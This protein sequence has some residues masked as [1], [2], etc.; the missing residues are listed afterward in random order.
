[1]AQQLSEEQIAARKAKFAAKKARRQQAAKAPGA[2]QAAG[3]V[4]DETEDSREE[5]KTSG[6]T[7]S[8]SEEAQGKAA[9]RPE[10]KKRKSGASVEGEAAQK[11]GRGDRPAKKDKK[12]KK[13]KKGD[14]RE[15]KGKEKEKRGNKEDNKELS[16]PPPAAGA[17]TLTVAC[18]NTENLSGGETG[19]IGAFGEKLR[20]SGADLMVL[21]ELTDAAAAEQLRARLPGFGLRF[22]SAMGRNSGNLHLALLYR[23]S[24]MLGAVEAHRFDTDP[25]L[26]VEM[27]D[28]ENQLPFAL[29]LRRGFVVTAVAAA[30]GRP[31]A[32]VGIH[33]KSLRGNAFSHYKRMAQARVVR[34]ALQPF[35]PTHD[36]IIG[37]D[38]NCAETDSTYSPL[39]D[40]VPERTLIRSE[41]EKQTSRRYELLVPTS[42]RTFIVQTLR[43]IDVTRVNASLANIH[44]V[45]AAGERR[46]DHTWRRGGSKAQLDHILFSFGREPQLQVCATRGIVWAGAGGV[47]RPEVCR[48]SS[49]P[50]GCRNGAACKFSHEVAAAAAAAGEGEHVSDH[51]LLSATFEFVLPPA[52][53]GGEGGGGGGEGGRAGGRV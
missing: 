41:L 43:H 44:S 50:G 12:R 18:W 31:L 24:S 25:A 42:Q 3:I 16:E 1:M 27:T 36:I 32:I 22:H 11:D 19:R 39:R 33:L 4:D 10:S 20:A 51:A 53:G 40:D 35:L 47:G 9:P 49:R 2:S 34:A 8:A 38:F 29:R 14:K 48:F 37:G 52:G 5:R 26:T 7:G 23:E 21:T 30:T 15:K 6:A 45:G 46:G 13:D 28:P 17:A